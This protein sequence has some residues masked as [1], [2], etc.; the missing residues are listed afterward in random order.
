[1]IL[2]NEIILSISIFNF[3]ESF[4]S[5]LFIY[6]YNIDFYLIIKHFRKSNR[7][8]ADMGIVC[9]TIPILG[10]CHCWWTSEYPRAHVAKFYGRL[11][12]ICSAW[13]HQNFP[14]KSWL[15]LW[16]EGLLHH[17]FWLQLVL[18]LLGHLFPT[19]ETTFLAKDHWRG[20]STRNAHMVHIVN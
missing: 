4:V 10:E 7:L 18:A 15:K 6:V 1:M 2:G 5:N 14:C 13:E 3:L 12:L 20:F 9:W 16:L 8:N 17:P 19:F 11:R